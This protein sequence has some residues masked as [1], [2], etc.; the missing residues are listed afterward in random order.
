[1]L[2]RL[3]M[4]LSELSPRFKKLLW[5]RWY[6]YLAG[7]K[8]ADW[9]FMNYGYASLDAAEEPVLHPDDEANR[10][11]IQLYRHVVRAVTSCSRICGPQRIAN[12]CMDSCWKLE[13]PSSKHRTSLPTSSK[14]CDR[15][16]SEGWL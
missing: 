12:V 10:Y 6:Q 14:H 1:M 9:Q 2:I 16:A 3:A 5:R 15:T 4:K 7:Y 13:W 11:A 8:M